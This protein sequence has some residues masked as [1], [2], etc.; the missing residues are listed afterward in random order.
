LQIA[1]GCGEDTRTFK[2]LK[3]LTGMLKNIIGGVD[4]ES[5]RR[6]CR[7]APSYEFSAR[8]IEHR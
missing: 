8:E 7:G 1:L 2:R 4:G 5:A 3:T 6:D